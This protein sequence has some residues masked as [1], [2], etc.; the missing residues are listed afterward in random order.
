MAFL[1]AKAWWGQG[2]GTE[3]ARAIVDYGF[4]QLGYARLVC[5]IDKENQ[6]SIN[7]ALKIGMAF[8]KEGEDEIGPFL[9]Y[10]KSRGLLKRNI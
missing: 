2:L 10:S 1:L 6:A 3:A 4:E 7:I 9:L 5:L 8:E